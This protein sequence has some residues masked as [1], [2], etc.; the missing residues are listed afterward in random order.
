MDLGDM[1]ATL[2]MRTRGFDK[3][4]RKMRTFSRYSRMQFNSARNSMGAF[5]RDMQRLGKQGERFETRFGKSLNNWYGN[6]H[7]KMTRASESLV[8]FGSYLQRTS[9]RMMRIGWYTS[10]YLTLPVLGAGA[11]TLAFQKRFGAVMNRIQNFLGATGKQINGLKQQIFDLAPKTGQGP[12][13]LAR[14]FE[15]VRQEGISAANAI[16][17]VESAAM[18]ASATGTRRMTQL[19]R[20]VANVTSG[21]G[22]APGAAAGFVTR[23]IGEEGMRPMRIG[24]MMG[25]IAANA[26]TLG[27]ELQDLG[28]AFGVVNDA[29]AL[30]W[31]IAGRL[32]NVF[33]DL[34]DASNAVAQSL[35]T[36]LREQG[37][38]AF[39][40][41][42]EKLSRDA[43]TKQVITDIFGKKSQQMIQNLYA[44]LPKIT[45]EFEKWGGQVGYLQE[46]FEG[47]KNTVQFQFQV[48]L[49][50]LLR[51][52]VIFGEVIKGPM[53]YVLTLLNDKLK[54]LTVWIKNLDQEQ[55]NNI[56]TWGKW[57]AIIGPAMM[58]LGLF[59]SLLGNAV[60]FL[61]RIAGALKN[62]VA[63]FNP[64]TYVIIAAA[65]GLSALIAKVRGVE[66][67]LLDFRDSVNELLVVLKVLV[68]RWLMKRLASALL[69]LNKRFLSVIASMKAFSVRMRGASM[70]TKALAV[71]AR[72]AGVA[73]SI[74]N[75][76]L[77]VAV[78]YLLI[79]AIIQVTSK[80][81]EFL[82]VAKETPATLGAAGRLAADY[83]VNS[84]ISGLMG[85]AQAVL[86]I[87]NV[88]ARP[89]VQGFR[90]IGIE[91]WN[92]LMAAFNPNKQAPK[93]AAAMN[94]IG[95]AAAKGF[96]DALNAIPE[97][98]NKWMNTRL[99]KIAKDQD[100]QYLNS[101]G[102]TSQKTGE[103]VST[104]FDKISA[105]VTKTKKQIKDLFEDF[106][107]GGKAA[108][109]K[110]ENLEKKLSTLWL[111]V[112]DTL[113]VKFDPSKI[114][115][116]PEESGARLLG[117]FSEV[118]ANE[119]AKNLDKVKQ[120]YG[121]I[122]REID[123][124]AQQSIEFDRILRNAFYG[125]QTS[126]QS[127]IEESKN[128]FKA[129]S[130]FLGDF[131]QGLIIKILS[132]VAATALLAAFLP[133]PMAGP[134][135]GVGT[136]VFGKFK[137]A[138]DMMGT[139][140][141]FNIFGAGFAG[142]GTVHKSGIYPV[143]EE[144]PELAYL[145]S[146]SEVVSND[147]LMAGPQEVI[148]R[149][150]IDGETI[151]LTNE[152]YKTKK[153]NTLG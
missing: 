131:I 10:M 116:K 101:L 68:G 144:G 137:K 5:D 110:T 40:R 81:W 80:L 2:S 32:N 129:F 45:K 122:R 152:R 72:T 97:N 136:G 52:F 106:E 46:K 125:M 47:V 100:I 17:V 132:A 138:A 88:I 16:G 139:T 107:K 44:N 78:W 7:D 49:S 30:S 130:N 20:A 104:S 120:G 119:M 64:F 142:G 82:R 83:F 89:L 48:A 126:L 51:T 118:R 28:A 93:F 8:Q 105:S 27:V 87:V 76:A 135:A 18:A 92:A 62:A 115:Y 86:D 95:Q 112:K 148:V 22:V 67:S 55:I 124:T 54:Q 71:S 147:D 123:M 38:P 134:G 9:E 24:T 60:V 108:A 57:I 4:K 31:R 43:D 79:E 133:A 94:R 98:W 66:N 12:F 85:L 15:I 21:M 69:F 59:G 73:V 84:I 13:E 1:H 146:G 35:K 99:I 113:G 29:G 74:L 127:A 109:N 77:Q 114:M 3:T 145:P 121:A 153:Q 65:A 26:R 34:L 141:I 56:L 37:L 149:G 11:A 36:T 111:S 117:A 58:A 25:E 75:K 50:T 41:Q 61:G 143:G 19:A 53:I 140:G 39:I 103:E 23:L 6:F 33:A 63:I 102:Q 91:T 128:I 90:Q 14:S 42:L 151:Y 150:H 96:Q 70:S